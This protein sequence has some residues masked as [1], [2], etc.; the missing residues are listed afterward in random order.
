[1]S[2]TVRDDASGSAAAGD[3]RMGRLGDLAGEGG[4]WL[5]RSSPE[6]KAAEIYAPMLAAALSDFGL[7]VDYERHRV[8]TE[9]LKI[10]RGSVLGYRSPP[11]CFPRTSPRV[12]GG[13]FLHF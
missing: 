8:V 3:V 10:R 2:D 6:R 13:E 1:L 5:R 12:A 9:H 11:P 4:T 7:A